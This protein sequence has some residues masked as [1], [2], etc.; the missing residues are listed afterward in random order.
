[1]CSQLV[2]RRCFAEMRIPL[3][4]LSSVPVFALSPAASPDQVQP[5]TISTATQTGS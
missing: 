2:C 5:D 4:Q 3:D 1:M